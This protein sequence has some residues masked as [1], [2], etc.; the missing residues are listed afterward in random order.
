L[1]EDTENDKGSYTTT[2]T[3]EGFHPPAIGDDD[4]VTTVE[5][6]TVKTKQV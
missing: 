2:I 5:N 4:D 6:T 1:P 3:K